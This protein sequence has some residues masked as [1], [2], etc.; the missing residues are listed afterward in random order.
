[1]RS[2]ST[3]HTALPAQLHTSD[4]DIGAL[5][6]LVV[7]TY[8]P[9]YCLFVLLC[10]LLALDLTCLSAGLRRAASDTRLHDLPNAHRVHGTVSAISVVSAVP[11]VL[12]GRDTVR[13]ILD[14]REIEIDREID[15]HMEFIMEMKFIC[16]LDSREIEIGAVHC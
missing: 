15:L 3:T 5:L 10:L 2:A 14:S 16:T 13:S 7:P 6:D 9:L 12:P 4:S 8:F 1:M 11:V